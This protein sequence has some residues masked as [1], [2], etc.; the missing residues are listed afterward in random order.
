MRNTLKSEKLLQSIQQSYSV[1]KINNTPHDVDNIIKNM[2]TMIQEPPDFVCGKDTYL[3]HF[4]VD[5]YQREEIKEGKLSSTHR[6]NEANMNKRASSSQ[7]IFST[8]H[9]STPPSKS[10]TSSLRHLK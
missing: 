3:E 8:M 9:Y 7:S 1:I 4:E 10:N 6:S 5:A 2:A